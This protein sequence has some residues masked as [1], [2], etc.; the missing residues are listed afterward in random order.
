[1]R[2]ANKTMCTP[3]KTF[4]MIVPQ[5]SHRLICII[6]NWFYHSISCV[7]FIITQQVSTIPASTLLV[8]SQKVTKN[9]N[10]IILNLIFMTGIQ[11]Y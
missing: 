3:L 11:I 9:E 8:S 10:T 6:T 2:L 1:M 4:P 7:L 5:M